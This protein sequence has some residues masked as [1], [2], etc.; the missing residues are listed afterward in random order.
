MINV[1]ILF[2]KL[3]LSSNKNMYILYVKHDM[4][5]LTHLG[6]TQYWFQ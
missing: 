4:I 3:Y 5:S 2:Y 1:I 6:F